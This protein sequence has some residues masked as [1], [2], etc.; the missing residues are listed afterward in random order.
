MS[1]EDVFSVQVFFLVFRETLES[2]I[3]VSVLLAFLQ[4]TFTE[5][6][7]EANTKLYQKLRLQVW[8]GAIAGLGL[9]LLI[10]GAFILV[11]YYLGTNL[12]DSTEKLWEATFSILASVVITV[13]G[14]GMLRIS[15]MKRKWR[16]KLAK[17]IVETHGSDAAAHARQHHHSGLRA[18]LRFW[19]R[20]YAMA[21]LPFITTLREG[22][23]AVVFVGGLGASQ[24]ATSLPLAVTAGIACGVGL[25][26]FM[27][28]SGSH[29]NIQYFLIGSTCFLYLVAAGLMSRGVWFIELHRFITKV[30][31]DIS[32]QGSGPGSYDITNSVWHV[33]CCN[34]ETDGPWMIFNALLGWQN[35][36]TYGSVISYNLY[37]AFIILRVFMAQYKEK[38]GRVPVLDKLRPRR[39]R[40]YGAV[41]GPDGAIADDEDDED[42]IM[43]RAARAYNEGTAPAAPR[44]SV[45]SQTP[46]VES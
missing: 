19:S 42:A 5:Q 27:Y 1:F 20:K 15:K 40:G 7:A 34:S 12:W 39:H 32:E 9:C 45:S 6:G 14:F 22:L 2:A 24:P 31:Q 10:G 36:A 43:R 11:F 21:F 44:D 23:E 38:H 33:N 35:S 46:L 29:L 13:M 8:L 28:R 3:I 37:W 17:M 4:R 25:G 41:G 16:I 30:G 18:R 26:W